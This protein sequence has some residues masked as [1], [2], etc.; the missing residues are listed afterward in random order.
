MF[1]ASIHVATCSLFLASHP[2][3]V[4][5]R[6]SPTDHDL[7]VLVNT[8]MAHLHRYIVDM[9]T[10]PDGVVSA[11]CSKQQQ[12]DT[13]LISAHIQLLCHCYN[14]ITHSQ[15]C[16]I[17]RQISIYI[18][19]PL[20]EIKSRNLHPLGTHKTNILRKFVHI[21]YVLLVWYC[22]YIFI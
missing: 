17:F 8:A 21:Q 5:F 4:S 9:S 20:Q 22:M 6:T 10:T 14:G 15:F 11:C 7:L 1:L 18:Y 2:Q 19:R 3:H 12:Q 16:K 13:H